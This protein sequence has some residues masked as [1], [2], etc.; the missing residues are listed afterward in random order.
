MELR[1]LVTLVKS[2]FKV[3]ECFHDVT[4]AQ[5]QEKVWPCALFHCYSKRHNNIEVWGGPEA[6]VLS[7]WI[8]SFTPFGF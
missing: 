6:M 7:F 2:D 3:L 1:A 4:C 5:L 8:A